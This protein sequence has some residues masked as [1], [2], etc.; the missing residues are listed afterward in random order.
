MEEKKKKK[1]GKFKCLYC[2]RNVLD[3]KITLVM[4]PIK[5]NVKFVWQPSLRFEGQ[6][7]FEITGPST[8]KIN[9]KSLIYFKN[10]LVQLMK[11]ALW[12]VNHSDDRQIT[13]CHK[14]KGFPYRL[15][16]SM[17]MDTGIQVTFFEEGERTDTFY[18]E[19]IVT[20]HSR[21]IVLDELELCHL[22]S[23]IQLDY[24]DVVK[25]EVYIP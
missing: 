2:D 8:C 24:P 7:Y 18:A 20:D 5:D 9:M 11:R 3:Q 23:N 1:S 19:N 21:S 13:M 16:F 4:Y 22:I 10:E 12:Y 25:R 14:S 17:K 6:V 15:M